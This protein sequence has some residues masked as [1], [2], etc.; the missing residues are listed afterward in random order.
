MERLPAPPRQEGW[1]GLITDQAIRR[2]SFDSGARLER[3]II[4][5]LQNWNHS[6][7]PLRRAKSG[8]DIKRS[9]DNAALIYERW[10]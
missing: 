8:A 3:A 5:W 1:F 4:S 7:R 9:L 2:G 6:R 10:H